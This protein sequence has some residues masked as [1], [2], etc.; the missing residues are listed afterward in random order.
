ML[1]LHEPVQKGDQLAE[2]GPQLRVLVPAVEHDVVHLPP[3]VL[4]LLQPETVADPPDHL[5]SAQPGVRG[6]T[7]N[8]MGVSTLNSI[9]WKLFLFC[10][11][12]EKP[13]YFSIAII[14][15]LLLLYSFFLN[16]L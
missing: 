3:A 1:A 6:R 4:R 5:V 9:T 16:D 13:D 7:W 2:G 8:D 12:P 10:D 15:I 14:F 11:L